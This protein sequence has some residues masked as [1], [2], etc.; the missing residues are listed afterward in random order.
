MNESRPCQ[1]RAIRQ[2]AVSARCRSPTPAVDRSGSS[3]RTIDARASSAGIVPVRE[4]KV[5]DGSHH[6][7]KGAEGA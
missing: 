7:I 6:G 4:R 2:D 3:A 5:Q 1:R